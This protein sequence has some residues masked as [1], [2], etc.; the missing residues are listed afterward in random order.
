MESGEIHWRKVEIHR[1][2][3]QKGLVSVIRIGKKNSKKPD[4]LEGSG[5]RVMPTH[6]FLEIPLPKRQSAIP[7]ALRG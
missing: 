1:R 7:A 2:R 4:F 6:P 5:T 3:R